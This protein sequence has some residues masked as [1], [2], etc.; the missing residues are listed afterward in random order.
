[1][2]ATTTRCWRARSPSAAPRP[3]STTSPATGPSTARCWPRPP[4]AAR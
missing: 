2:F 1:V 4:A 3:A